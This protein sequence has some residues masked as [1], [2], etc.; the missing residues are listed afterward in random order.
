[1]FRLSEINPVAFTIW[2][3]SVYWYGIAYVIGVALGWAQIRRH[4]K[5]LSSEKLSSL[6]TYCAFAILLGGRAFYVLL[7]NPNYYLQRPLSIVNLQEGGMS[8]HGALTGLFIAIYA[9]AKKHKLNWKG[10]ADLVSLAAPIG[11]CLGRLANYINSELYGK[12]STL[13]WAVIFSQVDLLP[14]HPTQLYEA[15]L[16]GPVL[17]II[18]HR[19]R[20]SCLHDK[21][22]LSGLFLLFY[23]AFRII[24]EIFREPENVYLSYFTLGQIL[25]VPMLIVGA[26][27]VRK[28]NSI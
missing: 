6:V 24:V 21:G 10:L 1:M 25:S 3:L 12:P 14:R 28:P 17:F 23:A 5:S 19:A 2:G 20:K 27:L 26:M 22:K 7:Y 13:P 11:I 4:E 9:F 16:E 8:F 15:L 18:L